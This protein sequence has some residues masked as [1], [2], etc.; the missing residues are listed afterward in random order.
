MREALRGKTSAPASRSTACYEKGCQSDCQPHERGAFSA[1]ETK[2]TH[3]FHLG[4]TAG[5]KRET[6]PVWCTWSPTRGAN[7]SR[8]VSLKCILLSLK[9][10]RCFQSPQRKKTKEFANHVRGKH[11]LPSPP[12]NLFSSQS[13][14]V[15]R[16]LYPR[17]SFRVSLSGSAISSRSISCCRSELEEELSPGRGGKATSAGLRMETNSP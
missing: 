17:F 2:L 11:C 16:V 12:L 4:L 8:S 10:N 1:W 14:S 6:N 13:V 3:A 5:K 7:T 15:C 9:P